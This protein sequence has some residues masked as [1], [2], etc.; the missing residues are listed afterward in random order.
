MAPFG[1]INPSCEVGWPDLCNNPLTLVPDTFLVGNDVVSPYRR[2]FGNHT[3]IQHGQH[4]FDATVGPHLGTETLQEYANSTIDISTSDEQSES[5]DSNKDDSISSTEAN[6]A[7]GA[8]AV[9][10]MK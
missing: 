1:Y 4:V 3:F 10:G 9:T 5:P 2:S 8:G 7:M 6:D